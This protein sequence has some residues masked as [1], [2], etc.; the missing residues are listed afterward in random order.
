[1]ATITG[2]PYSHSVRAPTDN[3]KTLS[4]SEARKV[5]AL[6][7]VTGGRNVFA[8]NRVAVLGIRSSWFQLRVN[9]CQKLRHIRLA[10]D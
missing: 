8:G 1:M 7:Y 5:H 9:V 4:V 2:K 6:A 3:L 10:S